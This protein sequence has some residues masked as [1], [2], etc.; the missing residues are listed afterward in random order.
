[1]VDPA[2]RPEGERAAEVEGDDRLTPEQVRVL[3]DKAR[4]DEK[5]TKLTTVSL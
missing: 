4:Q 5:G 3:I 2:D 1:M